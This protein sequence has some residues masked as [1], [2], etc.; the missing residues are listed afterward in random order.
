MR[1]GEGTEILKLLE[2]I[3]I[4]NEKQAIH[5]R[6]GV[7]FSFV[8]ASYQHMMVCPIR[9]QE[10]GPWQKCFDCD[11]FDVQFQKLAKLMDANAE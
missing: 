9:N 5:A 3:A 6:V 8:V 7:A 10:G 11:R 2:R 4:A 1:F